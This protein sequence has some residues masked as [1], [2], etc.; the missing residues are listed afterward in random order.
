MM[1]KL[2]EIVSRQLVY[3]IVAYASGLFTLGT[4]LGYNSF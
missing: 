2:G 1:E 3:E 4:Y